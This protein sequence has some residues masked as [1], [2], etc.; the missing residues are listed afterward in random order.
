MSTVG[1]FPIQCPACS[2]VVDIP[3]NCE[4]V[5]NEAAHQGEARLV[6][7]PDMSDIWA[8]MWTHEQEPTA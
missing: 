7:E 1:T 4:V 6:C 2:F 8:H 3:V 5:N